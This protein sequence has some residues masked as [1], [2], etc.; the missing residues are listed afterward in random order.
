M[1]SLSLDEGRPQE[2]DE[3]R[4]VPNFAFGIPERA[5]AAHVDF[6]MASHAAQIV[7]EGLQISL[8]DA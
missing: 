6:D 2:I 4:E 7:D 1:A 8:D 3:D 5:D